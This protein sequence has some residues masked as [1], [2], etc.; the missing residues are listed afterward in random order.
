MAQASAAVEG[1][2]GAVG[3]LIG[4]LATYPLKTIYTLQAIDNT[5]LRTVVVQQ[6]QQ[7]RPQDTAS[8]ENEQGQSS[9]VHRVLASRLL[10]L[11]RTYYAGI[12]PAILDTVA[13]S[14]VYFYLYSILRQEAVRRRQASS[15][16]GKMANV[17]NRSARIG[18][19]ESL[20]VAA[21]AGVGNQAVT[22]PAQVVTTRMQAWHKRHAATKGSQEPPTAWKVIKDV[23]KDDGVLG[24]WAGF[25]PSLLLVTN[26]AVQYMLYEWLVARATRTR[27]PGGRR[28]GPVRKLGAGEAFLL[29]ALAKVGATV[30]TYP[31]IVVKARLQAGGASKS[32][33]A[34][35][36]GV[37]VQGC[38]DTS[39]AQY[40]GTVDALQRIMREEGLGGF[41]KGMNS[42][43]L[44]TALS[45]A[46]LMSVREQVYA[47]THAALNGTA[48]DQRS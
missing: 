5:P 18:V 2:S 26:P 1:L 31:M 29:G 16:G 19:L 48:V 25:V 13:S 10:R 3:S 24:F 20:L 43:I 14:A 38:G 28:P 15:P 46:L 9:F 41:F 8:R 39:S 23:Y 44:Q 36:S 27:Q 34:T 4:L 17:D 47:A 21:L 12:G 7:L 45:A 35:S 11:L 40:T 22:T 30:V 32:G 33:A 42:K 37:D 6:P